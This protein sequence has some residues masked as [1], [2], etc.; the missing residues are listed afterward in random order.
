MSFL[1]FEFLNGG[2]MEKNPHQYY[3]VKFRSI[4]LKNR[5]V[6][7]KHNV[8]KVTI[9]IFKKVRECLGSKIKIEMQ[10]ELIIKL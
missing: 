2:T 4:Y 3:L 10:L 5:C 1:R 9:A 6:C 7:L 8:T